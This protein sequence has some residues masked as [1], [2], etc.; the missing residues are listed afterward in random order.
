VHIH[1]TEETNSIYPHVEG[2]ILCTSEE[3]HK[4]AE[5]ANEMGLDGKDRLQGFEVR[6]LESM[7]Q[8]LHESLGR[9]E[10]RERYG[11][12]GCCF[13]PYACPRM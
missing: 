10:A 2:I 11:A 9:V 12:W 8:V 7:Q 1:S 13:A 6:F 3:I 4:V 5:R